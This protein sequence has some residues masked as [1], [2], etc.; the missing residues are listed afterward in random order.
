MHRLV[1]TL[2]LS[3]ATVIQPLPA[4]ASCVE[5]PPP[6]EGFAQAAAVFSGT[7]EQ[8]DLGGR[9]ATVAV[10]TVW[11]GEV[12]ESVQ[13]QGT[14]VL[15]PNM[16]TSIDRSYQAGFSYVFFVTPGGVGFVDN[17]C[18]LTQEATAGLIAQLDEVSGGSG[19]TP[20]PTAAAP[21]E[22]EGSDR[23]STLVWSAAGAGLTLVAIAA[24]VRRRRRPPPPE[25]E[26]FRLQR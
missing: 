11:K 18:S 21:T 15:D 24:V 25:V 26:G 9:L 23:T 20:D 22:A 19:T 1:G 8:L 5:P 7:V 12:A 13:V 4:V 10:D 2:I 17:A 3:L 14:E 16:A 6:A